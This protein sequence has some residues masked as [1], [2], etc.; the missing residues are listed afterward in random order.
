[1]CT[2]SALTKPCRCAGDHLR[3]GGPLAS[4]DSFPAG[5]PPVWCP[6]WLSPALSS[7]SGQPNGRH[8]RGGHRPLGTEWQGPESA[9]L[10][11]GR[12]LT[13][14]VGVRTGVM[15][16]EQQ[17]SSGG[18]YGANLC[19]G[20]AAVAPIGSGELGAGERRCRHRSSPSVPVPG[21]PRYL[22]R[23]RSRRRGC[24]AVL[25][26]PTLTDVW[27]AGSVPAPREL[28][29]NLGLTRLA[30]RIVKKLLPYRGFT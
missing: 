17:L 29:R 28:A 25:A 21:W 24:S 14:A 12:Q 4:T 3:S 7:G 2:P 1:M 16:A 23:L 15:P 9:L 8:P 22:C 10:E 26:L 6:A 13:Q 30:Q 19:G 27:R 18:K 20:A 11:L 5:L